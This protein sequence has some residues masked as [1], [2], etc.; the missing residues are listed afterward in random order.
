MNLKSYRNVLKSY[1]ES[2]YYK[3]K[4]SSI[5]NICLEKYEN[6]D[7]HYQKW[8][9][10]ST[11][12]TLL[13]LILSIPISILFTSLK[14]TTEFKTKKNLVFDILK[15]DSPVA[16]SEFSSSQLES[17]ISVILSQFNSKQKEAP[18]ITPLSKSIQLEPSLKKLSYSGKNITIKNI[19]I[20]EAIDIGSRLDQ[21]SPAVKL[22]QFKITESKTANNYFTATFSL[23]HFHAPKKPKKITP[24]RPSFRSETRPATKKS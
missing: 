19:N 1:F 17:R 24:I 20:K 22:V 7:I 14:T 5:Y 16:F 15:K 21:I 10:I 12:S 3:V 2:I 18:K 11:S 13:L 9:Q 23:V 6:L 8:I 4:E